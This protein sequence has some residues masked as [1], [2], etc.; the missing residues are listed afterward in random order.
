[1]NDLQV[2]DY[3]GNQVRTVLV[4]DEP[5]WV[6]R[7]VC[8]VLGIGNSRMVAERLDDDE[9]GVSPRLPQVDNLRSS[10]I[11]PQDRVVYQG[12]TQGKG[13]ARPSHP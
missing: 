13:T 6:L 10:P 4:G 8:D 7:D 3:E 9:K 12:T 2:F 5:W 11:H 1:M